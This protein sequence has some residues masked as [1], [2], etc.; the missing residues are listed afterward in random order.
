MTKFSQDVQVND[1]FP[2]VLCINLPHREDRRIATN[3][4][5]GKYNIAFKFFEASGPISQEKREASN[6]RLLPGETGAFDSHLNAIIHARNNRWD[7][8][9]ILE[10]DIELCPDFDIKFAECINKVPEDWDMIYFG[11]NHEEPP[12]QLGNGLLKCT[13][14]FAIHCIAVRWSAYNSIIKVCQDN[15]M[16]AAIDYLYSC[17]HD[18]IGFNAYAFSPA[19]TFQRIDY[20]DIQESVVDYTILRKG[21]N[22]SQ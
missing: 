11:G 1:V 21:L 18:C 17:L 16:H 4:E 5:L 2:N 3:Q 19:L 6:T 15:Y 12:V 14:T 13:R 22:A 20:S 9:L 8:V 7:N 10:D